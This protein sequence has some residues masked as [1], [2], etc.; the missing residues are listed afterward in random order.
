[1]E[2]RDTA[3]EFLG[4]GWKFPVE[5]DPVTGRVR[6]A[7]SEENIQESVRL[8]LLTGKGERM[9]HPEFGCDLR[10]YLFG[11]VTYTAC[12]QMA[13]EVRQALIRWEPRIRDIE[14]YVEL[15]PADSARVLVH[16]SYVVRATNNPYNLV[17]P[18]YINEGL[19]G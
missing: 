14:T 8:I 4:V 16:I 3:R 6:T 7:S 18:Y 1:M 17:Y 2:Y 5:V 13:Q 15:D 9:M 11:V 12:T 10:R 19:E